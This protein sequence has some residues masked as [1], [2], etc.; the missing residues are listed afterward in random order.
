[1]LYIDGAVGQFCKQLA[2]I[3]VVKFV[4][5]EMLNTWAHCL[6]WSQSFLSLNPVGQHWFLFCLPS[7]ICLLVFLR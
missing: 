2:S 4:H 3:I 5:A 6:L 1:M 7:A